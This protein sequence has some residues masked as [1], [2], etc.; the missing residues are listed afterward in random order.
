MA[1]HLME[2]GAAVEEAGN[3]LHPVAE[4]N[5]TPFVDV[6]LVLLV[7]FMVTA[8]L[9]MLQVPVEL[10][11]VDAETMEKPPAP[12]VLVLNKQRRVFLDDNQ[13]SRAALFERLKE[14]NTERPQA[15]VYVGADEGVPYGEVL[16]LLS[17]A[18]VAGFAQVSL[19]S[20]EPAS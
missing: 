17:T 7:V 13:V 19:L 11:K 20:E 16:K 14:L 12:I 1:I 3:E 8:P 15:V 18:G 6:M 4:I 2:P 5:V 9:M 10:P